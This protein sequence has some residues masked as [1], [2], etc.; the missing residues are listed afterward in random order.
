MT[1]RKHAW[2]THI[3]GFDQYEG[4]ETLASVLNS[5]GEAWYSGVLRV[6]V[7]PGFVV[8]ITGGVVVSAATQQN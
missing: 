8:R 1:W 2:T 4:W 5:V 6:V 3:G 7:Q